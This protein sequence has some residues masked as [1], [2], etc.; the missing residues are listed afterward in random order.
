MRIKI[1]LLLD[2]LEPDE[3]NSE[4][5][6]WI[7]KQ[8]K[9][10]ISLCIINKLNTSKISK[11]KSVFNKYS[12]NRI[13]N[14]ILFKLVVLFEKYLYKFF[15]DKYNSNKIKLNN[16]QIPKIYVKP[17]LSKKRIY[18]QY[19]DDDLKKIKDKK[20]DLIIRMGSGILKGDILFS[21]KHGVLSFHHADNDINRG[22]P[23]GFWEV[24]YRQSKTGFII[25]QLN[26]TLDGGNILRKGFFP[27]KIFFYLNQKFIYKK[28]LYYFKKLLS[29]ISEN[30]MLPNMTPSNKYNGK[31][32]KDPNFLE[33]FYYLYKTYSKI[34]GI[35]LRK[36]FL[37]KDTWYVAYKEKNHNLYNL[38]NLKV[39]ENN[40]NCFN[41]DP[42]IYKL[43]DQNYIFVES[44]NFKKKRGSISV[45]KIK[46]HSY[47]F[48]GEVLKEKFH[49]SFPFIFEFENKI[50]MCP[51]TNQINEIRLYENISFPNKW[52]YHST[53]MKNV[54][55]ADTLIFEHNGIWW[56]LTNIDYSE[57][58]D[59]NSELSLYYSYE[60]PLT[61]KWNKHP[62][63]PLIIDPEKARNAGLIS[64]NNKLYRVS[65][66][67]E[68]GIYGKEIDINIID[69]ISTENYSEKTIHNIKPD[70]KKRLFATHHF[71]LNDDYIVV[72]C[73]KK[74]YFNIDN[75]LK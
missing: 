72:D 24:F 9:L 43:K 64:E 55:A 62:K 6:Q 7:D 17:I 41:A 49:L 10:E 73:C 75:G 45:Y 29:E 15:F 59:H 68:F 52:K 61:S 18:Y 58:N 5:I 69:M 3:Y 16:F 28:S 2:N 54:S 71:N 30:N 31:I 20:L 36:C 25:Q 44:F 46:K 60:G 21:S 70:F 48:L 22:G 1:G 26:E 11:I 38:D 4:L 13:I 39:I 67:N 66:K 14:K 12:I 34:I 57:I 65:Q 40:K 32:Y 19:S 35:F 8:D 42:F 51:E 50:F 47:E 33:L 53:L 56:L 37:E 27:T 74:N 23:A 63:N